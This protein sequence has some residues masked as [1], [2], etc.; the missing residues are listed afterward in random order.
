MDK[1]CIRIKEK[2]WNTN[3]R[4]NQFW[5]KRYL[6]LKENKNRCFRIT[7]KLGMQ[8]RPRVRSCKEA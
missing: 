1:G 3:P 6:L 4:P 7:L 8:I 5:S 2:K